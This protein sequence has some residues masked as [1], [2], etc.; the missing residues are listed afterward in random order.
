M[1]VPERFLTILKIHKEKLLKYLCNNIKCVLTG[2]IFLNYKINNL[3][4]IQKTV[5]LTIFGNHESCVI[6]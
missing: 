3:I 5:S 2:N 1:H 6:S 4:K